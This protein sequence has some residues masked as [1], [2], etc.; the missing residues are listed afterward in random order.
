LPDGPARRA[1]LLKLHDRAIQFEG[2]AGNSGVPSLTRFIDF[3]EKLIAAGEDWSK[4]QPE[5]GTGNTV[6]VMSIHKSKGLEFPVV[7]V[8]DLDSQFS[9]KD[10]SKDCVTDEQLTL[11][12]KIIDAESNSRLDSPAYQVIEERNRRK[13]LAEEMRILYV[14]MTRAMNRLI[15]VGCKDRDSCRN[16]LTAANSFAGQS[17]P[18]WHLETYQNHLDWILSALGS[19]PLLYQAFQTEL[20]TQTTQ[21]NLFSVHFYDQP[22]LNNL[23]ALIQNYKLNTQHST[24]KTPVVKRDLVDLKRSLNWQYPFGNAPALPAKR[25]VTQWTHRN[26][27]FTKIDYSLAFDRKPKAVFPTKQIDGRTIGTATHLVIS[28][29]DLAKPV[30]T[31]T[32]NRLIEK[33]VKDGAIIREIASQ[34]NVESIAKFFRSNLGQIVLSKKTVVRQ[35]WPFTFAVPAS[36]WSEVFQETQN[37]KLKTQDFIIV[38]GII[39]LLVETPEGLVIIDFKTDDVSAEGAQ[40]RAELYRGQ[41]DLYAQ[42][43]SIILG[44]E[45]KSKWLCFL[46]PGCEVEV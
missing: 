34:I 36:Q 16:I 4:P 35:E 39:D 42:A 32:V 11:G 20:P 15:L 30:T 8:A 9:K 28:R 26:D 7:F 33:L 24:L 12:L 43:A 23:S 1:N 13:S 6:R 10:F 38:Q 37:S 45:V 21:D 40:K 17:I 19:E 29:L 2:F 31:E 5:A 27:E 46:R 22:Q 18:S 14:A 25:T 41:L 3:I 44:Q